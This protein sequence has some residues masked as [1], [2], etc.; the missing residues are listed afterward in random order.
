[1]AVS[2]AMPLVAMPVY[3]KALG[4]QGWGLASYAFLLQLMITLLD[5]GFSQSLVKEMAGARLAGANTFRALWRGLERFYGLAACAVALILA[6][7][8]HSL[9][10]GVAGRSGIDVDAARHIVLLSSLLIAV[11]LPASLYR[12]ALLAAE[13]HVPNSLLVIGGQLVRHGGAMAVALAFG[14]PEPYLLWMV[15]A[16]LGESLSRRTVLRH[17][18]QR[19]AS[20]ADASAAAALRVREVLQRSAKMS[21]AVLLGSLAVYM[22]R[23]LVGQSLP[24]EQLGIY[25]LASTA[26]IGAT[27][28]IYPICQL[29]L[30]RLI[31]ARSDAGARHRVNRRMLLQ[32]SAVVLAVGLAYAAVGAQVIAWWLK[33]DSLVLQ[34]MPL[35][36]WLLLGSALNAFYNIGYLNWIA[37][38][39]HQ[40]ILKVYGI[41]LGAGALLVPWAISRYGLLGAVTGWI[42]VNIVCFVASTLWITGSWRHGHD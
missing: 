33:S 41:C 7:L 17:L 34:V 29:S 25:T 27:Q 31:Q 15:A 1:M 40:R 28:L 38:G 2:T 23:F 12:S 30:P 6:L 3:A 22:D 9:A 5:Q 18:I 37:D 26:A 4:A 11:Q 21:L 16:G 24:V 39:D 36:S 32:I 19:D 14:Q 20:E 13:W 10:T 42:L 35:L 8:S